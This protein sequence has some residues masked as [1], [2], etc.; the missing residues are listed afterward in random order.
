[1]P[2]PST[3]FSTRQ[4]DEFTKTV[5]RF[6]E[7][8]GRH[9]LPWRQTRQPYRILVSEVML[10]QTQVDRVVPYYRAFLRRFPSARSLAEAPLRDVLTLWQG[11]G[12]NRRA[13]LLHS[14]AQTV[15][16]E[17]GGRFPRTYWELGDLPGVGP[18]TAGAIMAFA[19]NEAV[20]L[21][22]TNVRTVYLHHFFNDTTGVSDDE[23]LALVEATLPVDNAREWYYALMDYGA[24][25]KRTIGNLNT[26]SRHYTK[27]SKF[28]GSD[29]QIRGAILR[30]LAR[31]PHTSTE[32]LRVLN[33]FDD[34][35]VD[36]QL[37]NLNREGL[38]EKL[39]QR[40]QLPT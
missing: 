11:L 29:R 26:K 27:Q 3:A 37:A 31:R 7:E 24:Y 34:C 15:T 28:Q 8:H 2:K 14:C 10:Q 21:V 17:R 19:Y 4:L 5:W 23:I 18:Y 16:R 9:Q 22:E 40:W 39:H 32:L 36:A 38:V 1:M 25:L 30:A 12:Y 6:Y 35:R 33:Q 13:K 20:P